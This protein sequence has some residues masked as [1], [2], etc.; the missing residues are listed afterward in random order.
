MAIAAT[1]TILTILHRAIPNLRTARRCLVA[2]ELVRKPAVRVAFITIPLS[3][4]LTPHGLIFDHSRS[5]ERRLALVVA[6]CD[7]RSHLAL[8]L[9]TNE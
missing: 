6:M 1:E 5:L 4:R 2:E 3:P 9:L 7:A 8:S